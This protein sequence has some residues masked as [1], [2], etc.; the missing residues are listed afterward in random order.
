MSCTTVSPFATLLPAP[1]A[2]LI[3]SGALKKKNWPICYPMT[4]HNIPEDIPA[5]KQRIVRFAYASYLV[6]RRGWLTCC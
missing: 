4:Y 5:E 3:K 1:Q 6:R 2:E